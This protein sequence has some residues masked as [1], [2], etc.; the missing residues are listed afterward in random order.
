MIHFT[1][2]SFF[3]KNSFFFKTKLNYIKKIE[4]LNFNRGLNYV[5]ILKMDTVIFSFSN[6]FLKLNFFFFNFNKLNFFFFLFKNHNIISNVFLFLK[7]FKKIIFLIDK[8]VKK[9][10][11]N[12]LINHNIYFILLKWFTPIKLLNILVFFNYYI[13]FNNFYYLLKLVVFK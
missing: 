10:T 3:F 12:L 2:L 5:N 13:R 1:F 11:I 6:Y 7:K 8:F 9:L 4:Y